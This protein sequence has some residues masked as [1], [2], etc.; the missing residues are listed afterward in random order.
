MANEILATAFVIFGMFGPPAFLLWAWIV[1]WRAYPE[2][3]LIKWRSVLRD[4]ALCGATLQ[5][6]AYWM[7][8]FWVQRYQGAEEWK[9]YQVWAGWARIE[10][11]SS[12]CIITLAALGKGKGRVLTMLSCAGLVFGLLAVNP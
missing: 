3:S 5:W 12:I 2:N 4:V 6:I 10:I 1:W 7:I 9:M 11:V 8:I